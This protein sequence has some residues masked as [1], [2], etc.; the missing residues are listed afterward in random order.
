M[1]ISIKPSSSLEN[2]NLGFDLL[3]QVRISGSALQGTQ[4]ETDLGLKTFAFTAI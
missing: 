2:Q 4:I 3:L 1:L